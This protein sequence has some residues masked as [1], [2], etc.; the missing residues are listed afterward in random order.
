MDPGKPYRTLEHRGRVVCPGCDGKGCD[1]CNRRGW[2]IDDK[3][4]KEEWQHG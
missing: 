4:A 2:M 3:A 1:H